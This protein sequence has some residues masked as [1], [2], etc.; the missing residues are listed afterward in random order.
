MPALLLR[1][2]MNTTGTAQQGELVEKRKCRRAD[3]VMIFSQV[4]QGKGLEKRS[5]ASVESTGVI[6]GL[7]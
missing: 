7:F 5:T 6:G 2:R 4:L 3:N 1:Y